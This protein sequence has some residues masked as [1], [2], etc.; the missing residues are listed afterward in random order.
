MREMS[1]LHSIDGWIF[2]FYTSVEEH[3]D[4]V[5]E[6]L[7]ILDEE[8]I[9]LQFRIL[10]IFRDRVDY[11]EHILVPCK[12]AALHKAT[13]SMHIVPFPTHKTKFE[14]FV[15]IFNVYRLFVSQLVN[16]AQPLD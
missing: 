14:S 6:F 1:V 11:F 7:S 4:H 5:D 8:S 9:F 2:I 16:V 13:C 3:F 12:L 10:S 15:W